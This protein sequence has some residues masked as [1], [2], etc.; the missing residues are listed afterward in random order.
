MK[1]F[2]FCTS[3][4]ECLHTIQFGGTSSFKA[5]GIVENELRIALENQLILDVVFSTLHSSQQ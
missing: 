1:L 5:T 3:G 2:H 4:Y